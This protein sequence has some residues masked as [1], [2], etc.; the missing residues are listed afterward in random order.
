MQ[1]LE[2][3]PARATL[4]AQSTRHKARS[5]RK[6]MS[7]CTGSTT[8]AALCH[9]AERNQPG[10]EAVV[11]AMTILLDRRPRDCLLALM[12]TVRRTRECYT[13]MRACF[14]LR[15]NCESN[16]GIVGPHFLRCLPCPANRLGCLVNRSNPQAPGQPSAASAVE[17]KEDRVTLPTRR[18]R[19]GCLP[20]C[21][22]AVP[23]MAP[24]HQVAPPPTALCQRRYRGAFAA[25]PA[26]TCTSSNT[27]TTTTASTTPSSRRLPC[28]SSFRHHTACL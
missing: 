3:E 26:T 10:D 9:G 27:A 1:S 19:G 4:R 22:G 7:H 14:K 28:Y 13:L 12:P 11:G 18:A 21:A 20:S 25:S 2:N 16:F 15:E 17:W 23:R 24:R 8:V 6:P 5:G